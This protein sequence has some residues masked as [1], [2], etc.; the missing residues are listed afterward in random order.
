MDPLV[1]LYIHV[2]SLHKCNLKVLLVRVLNMNT[3]LIENF[4]KKL[5]RPKNCFK[6][7]LKVN[8]TFSLASAFTKS[9]IRFENSVR[10]EAVFQQE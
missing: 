10:S 6:I 8:K 2:I 5:I 9:E 1:Q 4:L 3:T 7:C